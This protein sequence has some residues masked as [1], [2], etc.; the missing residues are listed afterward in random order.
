MLFLHPNST[1]LFFLELN[2][3][4]LFKF[5]IFVLSQ[6]KFHY[7]VLFSTQRTI[8][9]WSKVTFIKKTTKIN[10]KEEPN[11]QKHVVINSIV[12]PFLINSQLT[13]ETKKIDELRI[14]ETC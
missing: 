8:L 7:N 2:S 13:I 3:T 11:N 12:W 1:F 14:I 6:S 4:V 5:N 9:I 10:V